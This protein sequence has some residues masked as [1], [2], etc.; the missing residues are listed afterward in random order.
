M[1][2]RKNRL[3]RVVAPGGSVGPL[4]HLSGE[5]QLRPKAVGKRGF[6][7]LLRKQMV[8]R[9]GCEK[10]AGRRVLKLHR[11]GAGDRIRTG[12]PLLGKHYPICAVLQT[13]EQREML[14][15]YLLLRSSV[16]WVL[17]ELEP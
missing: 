15:S 6:D 3:A 4:I 14:S 1:C 7:H 12:D 13:W 9:L 16:G 2:R 10:P 8:C 5:G 17:L 11:T